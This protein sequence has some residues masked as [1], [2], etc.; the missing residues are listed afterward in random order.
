MKSPIG[1][2]WLCAALVVAHATAAQDVLRDCAAKAQLDSMGVQALQ[3]ECPGI[4]QALEDSSYFAFIGE[5]QGE[6]LTR[7]SITDLLDLQSRY[8]GREASHAALD[9]AAAERA[10]AD[11]KQP[12]S[13]P[14]VQRKSWFQLLMDWVNQYLSRE[15]QRDTW[16]GRWLRGFQIPTGQTTWVLGLLSAVIVGLAIAIVIA[17][18]RASGLLRSY[19]RRAVGAGAATKHQVAALTFA[20]LEAIPL[21]DRAALLLKLLVGA[22]Q[23]GGRLRADQALTHRELGKHAVFDDQQ[24]RDAFGAI[25]TLAESTLYG[26]RSVD[27]AALARAIDSG[28]RMHPELSRPAESQP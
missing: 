17:E 11:L 1:R 15:S 5:E 9:A 8:E 10:V 2:G 16:L 3:A 7:D 25:A 27:E 20:D 22:L 13:E 19:R 14:K 6:R 4:E 26:G 12:D 18:L 21:R 23:R 24:Q 28:Q